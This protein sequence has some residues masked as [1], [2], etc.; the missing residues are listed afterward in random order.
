LGRTHPR[1]AAPPEKTERACKRRRARARQRAREGREARGGE[2]RGGEGR[3][4]L[5]DPSAR[6]HAMALEGEGAQD[7]DDD[8]SQSALSGHPSRSQAAPYLPLVDRHARPASFPRSPSL[9]P[10]HFQ[11]SSPWS[12]LLDTT[13]TD[14][15]L[16]STIPLF[17]LLLLTWMF[18]VALAAFRSSMTRLRFPT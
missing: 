2:G 4:S 10:I 3:G 1:P 11:I 13:T 17:S 7:E 9:I 15:P 12:R 6:P 16:P 5:P 8:G 18:A 14:P